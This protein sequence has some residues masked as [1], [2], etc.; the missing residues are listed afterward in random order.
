MTKDLFSKYIWLMDTIYRS[1]KITFKEIKK[2]WMESKYSEGVE[3]SNRTFHHWR[4]AIEN[5]FDINIECNRKGGYYYYYIENEE[6][7]QKGKIRNWLLDTFSVDRLIT[8]SQS[9]R[10]RILFEEIPSGRQFLT[11]IIEAMHKNREIS[12]SHQSYWYAEPSRY[13]LQPYYL[14]VFRQ[15]WYVSGFCLERNAMRTF[16]LDRINQLDVLN[17]TFEYPKDFDPA[18]YLTDNYGIITEDIPTENVRLKATGF[19]RQYLRALP[20]H[21]SQIETQCT[22]EYSIFEYHIKPTFDFKQQ[23]LY[24]ERKIEVLAPEWFRKDIA[25]T[26]RE[27]MAFYE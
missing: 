11:T 20:L 26:L 18:E 21:P 5:L 13:T 17:T 2:L 7:L 23:L 16:S 4:T 10:H 1:K 15:R 24:M 14:K 22:D 6:E 25:Q 3:L 8:E 27:M 19:Q 9:L 12:L